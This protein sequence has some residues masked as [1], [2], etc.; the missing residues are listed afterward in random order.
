MSSVWP[1]P[2]SRWWKFD[3]HTH[4]PASKD[5]PW[6]DLIGTAQELKPEDW[7]LKYMLAGIDCVAVT[8]HNSGAW[9]DKLKAAYAAMQANPPAGFRELHLFPGVEISVNGGFHLLAIFGNQT[10]TSDIDTLLGAV[11]YQDTKGDSDGVTREA[12][13]E[14]IQA[15]VAAGGLPIPAHADS[16][17]GLLQLE[18]E[19]GLKPKLDANTV[20]QVLES[21]DILAME[22]VN[23]DTSKPAIYTQR[24]LNW[25]EVLGSDCH[26]FRPPYPNVPGSRYT[27]VKMAAPSLEG[28]R[29]ALLDGNGVS[30]RRSDE[31][32]FAPFK[33][34]EH[35]ITSITVKDARAMGRNNASVLR[36]SPYF[37]ALVGGR[38]TGKSTIIHALRLA[39][40]RAG[41]INRLDEK[42]EPRQTFEQFVKVSKNRDDRGGLLEQTAVALELHRD[43]VPHRLSWQQNSAQTVI[44]EEHENGEWKRSISQEVSPQRFPLRIF[45]Q[46]QIAALAGENTLALLGVID[47]AAETQSAKNSFEDAKQNYLAQRAKLRELDGR[48]KAN[49]EIQRQFH[50]VERKLKTFEQADHADVLKAYQRAR[51]QNQAVQ[52]VFQAASDTAQKIQ[53]LTQ[54]IVIDALPQESFAD[55]SD[56]DILAVIA[57]LDESVLVAQKA[58]DTAAS[59]LSTSLNA[60]RQNPGLLS[61][62]QRIEAAKQAYEKLKSDL[63]AQGVNDPNEYARLV[64]EKQRLEGESKKMDLLQQERD[65]LAVECET[66]WLTLSNARKTISET[67]QTFLGQVLAQNDFVQIDLVPFGKDART[68][69]RSLREMLDLM[70]ERFVAD[71]LDM[72]GDTAS[73]GLVADWVASTDSEIGLSKLKERLIEACGGGSTLGGKFKNYLQRKSESHPEFIDHIRCWFPEDSL[74]VNYSRK[75]DG[76]DFQPIGQASAGQRAA[77]MLAFLLAQGAEPL[78]LDQPEDD[79]DNHLIYELVVRQIREN[80]LRRQLIIVTHNP[81]IVVNGDAE[82]LF[83]LDFNG[84]CFVKTEGALQQQAVREEVCRIMEGGREAFSRRWHRLGR[85]LQ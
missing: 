31:D 30:I 35:F 4:S 46:G 85:G 64:Q 71:I 26:N 2:G 5:T 24:K 74:L 48:L 50:D 16:A 7:L 25:A 67:R 83:A 76:T 54:E 6:H 36:F 47:E 51:Q 53:S 79:L 84:Q 62:K 27:W 22:F 66:L 14:V 1:Y 56:A 38:G 28:L 19:G 8:D 37:N 73:S 34:P 65:R 3:F 72:D 42:S 32:E 68:V 52:E 78:V 61:W 81:N 82:M 57:A 40:G 12:A 69:E 20:S 80:K 59:Q 29:L 58:V 10:T 41:E 55:Q 44:V 60:L 75:G 77:A 39:S 45:S 13:S 43:A 9:I 18:A 11:K 49:A 21:N 23:A 70:D 33:T 63:L 17:K 15:I